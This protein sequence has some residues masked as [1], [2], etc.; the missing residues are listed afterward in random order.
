MQTDIISKKEYFF[1]IKAIN[2]GINSPKQILKFYNQYFSK[3]TYSEITNKLSKLTNQNDSKKYQFL[4]KDRKGRIANYYL[5]IPYFY[6]YI[7]KHF[8]RFPKLIEYND[9]YFAQYLKDYIT[10]VNNPQSHSI[11]I[12]LHRFLIHTAFRIRPIR[13]I[14]KSDIDKGYTLSDFKKIITKEKKVETNKLHYEDFETFQTL[15]LGYVE[16]LLMHLQIDDIFKFPV[17]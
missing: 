10:N 15:C 7:F 3:V 4:I 16:K 11:Y 13:K 12:V 6:E 14:K 2:Q 17:Q 1:L 5:N 8:F 9:P